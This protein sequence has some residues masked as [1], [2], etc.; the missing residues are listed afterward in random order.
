MGDEQL[1][2]EQIQ[3]IITSHLEELNSSKQEYDRHDAVLKDAA[4]SK[5][6]KVIA[7]DQMNKA[8]KKYLTASDKL[9]RLGYQPEYDH[10]KKCYFARRTL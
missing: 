7:F 9:M 3:T 10:E 5:D 2:P 4:T 8:Y 1:T 6:K